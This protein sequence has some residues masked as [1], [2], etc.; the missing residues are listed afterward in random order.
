[1]VTA[2][3]IRRCGFFWQGGAKFEIKT[4]E[5]S[6]YFTTPVLLPTTSLAPK[7]V[8]VTVSLLDARRVCTFWGVNLR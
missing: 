1:V 4:I 5:A 3:R 2:K 7:K 8:D 6:A